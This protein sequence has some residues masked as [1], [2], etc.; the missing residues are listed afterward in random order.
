MAAPPALILGGAFGALP[1]ARSLRR[2]RI[3]VH[4]YDRDPDA[5]AFSSRFVTPFAPGLEG[6]AL[7]HQLDA[8]SRGAGRR[9]VLFVTSD[10]HLELLARHFDDLSSWFAVLYRDADIVG[11]LLSKESTAA[12]FADRGVPT[13]TTRVIRARED[14]QA[15]TPPIVVK[16]L[17]QTAWTESPEMMRATS[18]F[19]ALR[20]I[21][22]ED[23]DRWADRLLL[24]GPFVAQQLV[25]AGSDDRYY[26]VGCRS[27]AGEPIAQ[28]TGKKIRTM[29]DGMG[30]ETVLRSDD[31]PE[32][33]ALGLEA[34]ERIG[35]V[36][37]AGV[38]IMRDA[39]TGKLYVIEI[40]HR[41][42][43][44]DGILMKAG[45]DLPHLYYRL[46]LG[47]EVAPARALRPAEWRSLLNDLAL[48]RRTTTSRTAYAIDLL[49]QVARRQIQ[50]N[51]LDP[52]DPG[53][54]LWALRA[55]GYTAESIASK[56]AARVRTK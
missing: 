30:S 21:T 9:P 14:L 36:G 10:R 11:A 43:L 22:K 39:P 16:P 45:I 4:C 34:L 5:V 53:P 54:T 42:G 12:L 26:F 3:A 8:F 17:V 24:A 37:V 46:A 47:E 27:R 50:I 13:P 32:V 38:D 51:E 20:L 56:I 23:L 55:W 40:N 35:A 48:R 6:E 2:Q 15:V 25:R 31:D 7:L 41:F 49:A 33:R 28:F 44:S 52:L 19:K 18:R 1:I 29:H